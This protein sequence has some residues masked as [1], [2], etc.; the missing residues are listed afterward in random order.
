MKDL[1]LISAM[2]ASKG[3]GVEYIRNFCSKLSDKFNITLHI[4]SNEIVDIVPKGINIVYTNIDYSSGDADNFV[5]YG[6]LAPYIRAIHKQFKSYLYYRKILRSNSIKKGS[7][8][9]IMDYDVFPLPF[10]VNGLFHKGGSIFLWIHSA[11]FKSKDKLYF[12]YKKVFKIFFKYLVQSKIEKVVVNGEY[13]K[14]ILQ[15]ELNLPDNL[16]QIIQYPSAIK[17]KPLSKKVARDKLGLD[18]NE[19]VVLFFGMLRKDK[20]IEFLIEQLAKCNNVPK[21]LIVGSEASVTRYE[22]QYWIK[23]YN[24]ENYFLD[25]NYI[26]EQKMALYYSASDLLILTYELESGSQSGPLSLAREFLLPAL[27]SDV[28]EIGYY[29]RENK[30]GYVANPLK[31]NSF[32]D[33]IDEYF[34]QYHQNSDLKDNLI[35]AKFN[36]SWLKAA[37]KYHKLFNGRNFD[38]T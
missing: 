17:Y 30:I 33:K 38:E 4:A 7:L 14:M 15:T 9:Y 25:L 21:L 6:C 32:S 2:Y 28:G 31:L 1:H 34:D 11:K 13:I 27:V 22:I 37:E 19:K 35:K 23:H 26:S 24:L 12:L 20:N 18:D 3:H 5:K 29:V 16:I 8:V 10:L 36:Y